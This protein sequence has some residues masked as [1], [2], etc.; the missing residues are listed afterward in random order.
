LRDSKKDVQIA[1]P[2]SAADGFPNRSPWPLIFSYSDKARLS[3][4]LI[5]TAL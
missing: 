1:E 3:I 2:Q 4:P 5:A